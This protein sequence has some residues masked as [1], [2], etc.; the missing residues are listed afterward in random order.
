MTLMMRFYQWA[1]TGIIPGIRTLTYGKILLVS[2]CEPDQ[3][4]L[5]SVKR[6]GNLSS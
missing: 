4:C 3:N 2:G 5:M 6:N 1:H